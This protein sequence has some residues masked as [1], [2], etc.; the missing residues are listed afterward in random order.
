MSHI[1]LDTN[2]SLWRECAAR[3]GFRPV[4][5]AAALALAATLVAP[6]GARVAQEE[7][8]WAVNGSALVAGSEPA[9]VAAQQQPPPSPP[10]QQEKEPQ[11]R[12]PVSLEQAQK[13]ALA[14]F[15]GRVAGA[16]TVESKGRNVHEI[17]IV[18]EDNHVRTL[19]VDAQTG[20]FL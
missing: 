2:V 1:R 16:K 6:A 18:G 19:R 17:R 3:R 7:P 8:A 9:F 20:A 15:Q 12:G 10:P 13:L 14:R 4:A 11:P 5:A